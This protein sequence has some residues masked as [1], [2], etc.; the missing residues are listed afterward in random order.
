MLL[1]FQKRYR[2]RARENALRNLPQDADFAYSCLGYCQLQQPCN[3]KRK[4]SEKHADGHPMQLLNACHAGVDPFVTYGQKNED[5]NGID[6]YHLVWFDFYRA[7]LS[8]HFVGLEHP[9]RRL[10]FIQRPENGYGQ[11]HVE[12]THKLLHVCNS[13]RVEARLNA[14]SKAL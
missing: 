9:A 5:E 3:H 7:D 1:S 13:S 6:Y 11:E 4:G 2:Q 14:I 12:Y 8:V 10:L